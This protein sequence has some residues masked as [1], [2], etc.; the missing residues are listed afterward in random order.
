[1]NDTAPYLLIIAS[2]LS[3]EFFEGVLGFILTTLL[4]ILTGLKIIDTLR[5][6]RK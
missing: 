4:I 3:L 6:W 5:K 1:M 2:I